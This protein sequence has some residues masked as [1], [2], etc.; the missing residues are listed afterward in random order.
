MSASGLTPVTVLTGFLGSGKTTLLNRLVASPWGAETALI[1]NELGAVAI[2]HA[3]VRHAAEDMVVL[4]S[5]CVCCTVA[6]ELLTT[7]RDL[8][9]RRAKGEVP[10]FKRVVIETTGLADPAPILH[11]LIQMPLVVAR[12]SLASVVT[13]VDAEHGAAT[14]DRHNEAVR[15]AAMADRI[16]IT[17]TDVAPAASVAALRDR[18]ATLNPGAVVVE[19]AAGAGVDEA[20]FEGGVYRLDARTE[21]VREWLRAEAYRPVA[22]RPLTPSRTA[23]RVAAATRHDDRIKSFVVT[24]AGAAELASLEEGLTFVL[25]RYGRQV[26]RMKGIATVSS[27]DSPRVLHGVAHTLYPVGRLPAWPAGFAPGSSQFVFIVEDLAPAL[28]EASLKAFVKA[29]ISTE[30]AANSATTP[31]TTTATP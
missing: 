11:T 15:Q 18:L 14:L 26:L 6:G 22:A 3:L 21:R 31:V 29:P 9:F 23:Q 19:S 16:V 1:I 24:L 30:Y 25:E 27:D 5:G 8:Y 10:A 7:L 13:T 20:F 2:D 12:Y 17:K 28:I 4:D